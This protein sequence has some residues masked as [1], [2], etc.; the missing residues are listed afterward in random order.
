MI[1]KLVKKPLNGEPIKINYGQ[2]GPKPTF[3]PNAPK[4][5]DHLTVVRALS[6][7]GP[8]IS[9][10]ACLHVNG[11]VQ[12]ASK[13]LI[14][15][16]FGVFGSVGEVKFFPDKNIGKLMMDRKQIVLIIRVMCGQFNFKL[17]WNF[18]VSM[19]IDASNIY[20]EVY[21]TGKAFLL[22]SDTSLHCC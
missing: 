15:L 9:D 13:K 21:S 2:I 22:S 14:E 4:G 8:G 1:E 7:G 20:M 19:L 6:P 11:L 16:K 18:K 12:N 5:W 3:D 10:K 17:L